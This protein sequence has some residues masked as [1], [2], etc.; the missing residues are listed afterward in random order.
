MLQDRVQATVTIDAGAEVVWEFL[1]V[2]RDAWWAD[3]RFEASAGS[4]LIETWV[5]EGQQLSATGVVTQC[6]EPRLLAFSWSEPGWDR[7]LDV[8]IRLG[9][10]DA[11]TVTVTETGFAI[12]G[13]PPTLP[14]E[15]EHGWHY[16]LGRL[17]RVSEGVPVEPAS[18]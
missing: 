15:H 16:H 9:G 5:E 10:D 7:P 4:P 1:T 8:V 3:M 18:E 14:D 6:E 12:A 17:R 13:T 2:R 11:T